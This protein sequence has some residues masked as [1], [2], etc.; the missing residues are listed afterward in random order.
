MVDHSTANPTAT[1]VTLSPSKASDFKTC[2]QLFKF[3]YVDQVPSVPTAPQARGTAVHLALEQ[4]FELPADQR[5]PA[6][7][8]GLLDDA[9]EIVLSSETYGGLL[10]GDAPGRAAFLKE[11][12][13]AAENYFQL[14]DPREVE[15]VSREK[16]V[17]LTVDTGTSGSVEVRG[18]VDRIDPAPDGTVTV[19]DYKTGKAPPIRYAESSFFALKIYALIVRDQLKMAPSQIRLLYL[20]D[21][22][23]YSL[24][25]ST[26]QLRAVEQQ[27]KALWQTIVRAIA[28]N[29]FPTR[30]SK[31]CGWCG[32]QP[33]CP[34]WADAAP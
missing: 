33:I 28:N 23:G 16:R 32:Y 31:L 11:A 29:N 13:E 6:Q 3:R 12:R 9:C 27:I 5:L 26:G 2:P 25:V 34:A 30:T 10:Q 24:P 8:L 17:S 14:E 19:V 21:S 20:G 1:L 22:V 7:L 4:L 15:P 18:I